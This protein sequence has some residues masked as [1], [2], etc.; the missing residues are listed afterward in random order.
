M[1]RIRRLATRSEDQ[2]RR[3]V[4]TAS[5]AQ[6][7]RQATRDSLTLAGNRTI[8]RIVQTDPN[9]LPGGLRARLEGL[10]GISLG[11]VR[12][13][14]G[15]PE[16]D[17]L[18]A[19]AFTQGASIHLGAGQE[20]HLAHEAWHVVQ[21]KQGRV[22]VTGEAGGR[23]LNHSQAL[24]DEADSMGARAR[25]A[26]P[27]SRG[28]ALASVSAPAHSPVQLKCRLCGAKSHNENKCPKAVRPET[29]EKNGGRGLTA[30]GPKERELFEAILP[31]LDL[32]SM[33]GPGGKSLVGGN[34]GKP[35][36][37]A[38]KLK[39]VRIDRQGL[40]NVQ[41]QI[42]DDSYACAEFEQDT[43]PEAIIAALR[44]SLLSGENEAA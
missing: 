30:A 1:R 17:R 28:A 37:L 10:S 31:R 41:F 6:R 23:P 29:E 39:S 43:E 18:N 11:D 34:K 27:A 9:R 26:Q 5:R 12:V 42:G 25:Q 22:P 38:P 24:E 16:P 36:G 19:F 15:S 32:E 21:Q 14:R 20:E 4:Q 8:S 35:N 33:Y 40:G 3:A 13:H 44:R 2:Q 7:A